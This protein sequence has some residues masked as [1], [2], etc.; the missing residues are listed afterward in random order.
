MVT[1]L[2]DFRA[3][4]GDLGIDGELS[5]DELAVALATVGVKDPHV[6]KDLTA[7]AKAKIPAEVLQ[8][9]DFVR[10]PAKIEGTNCSNCM[11]AKDGVCQYNVEVD[12]R[13]LDVDNT[14]C[15]RYWDHPHAKRS[16][17]P[18][19]TVPNRTLGG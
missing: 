4:V 1:V 5:D 6:T 2:Q 12:L 18:L 15:C 17:L 9:A 7:V 11:F 13:G 19:G 16:Y 10:L 3:F 14:T 8:K